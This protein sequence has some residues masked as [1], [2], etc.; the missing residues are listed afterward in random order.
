MGGLSGNGKN[1]QS[2]NE[3]HAAQTDFAAGGEFQPP[4]LRHGQQ[5]DGEVDDYVRDVGPDEPFAQIDAVP[6]GSFAV[7]ER[8]DRTALED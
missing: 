7:P 4:D 5:Q 3:E 1:S 8:G 6:V 2:A